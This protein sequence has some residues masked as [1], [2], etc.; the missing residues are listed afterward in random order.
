MVEL[1]RCKPHGMLFVAESLKGNFGHKDRI[2]ELANS[3]TEKGF[4]IIS[5]D[6]SGGFVYFKALKA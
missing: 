6:L 3:I 1:C 5:Q 2:T 4:D